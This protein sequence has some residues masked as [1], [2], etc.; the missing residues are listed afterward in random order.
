MSTKKEK[1]SEIVN[2]LNANAMAREAVADTRTRYARGRDEL[3]DLY[4]TP[5]LVIKLWQVEW[6]KGTESK[7][8]GLLSY[9]AE[10][11]IKSWRDI[12]P[13]AVF[14]RFYMD[15]QICRKARKGDAER[16]PERIVQGIGRDGEPV[17]YISVP[18]N[19][20][21]YFRALTEL[22]KDEEIK[23]EIKH[24]VSEQQKKP[25]REKKAKNK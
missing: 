6:R 2:L 16:H 23:R 18:R 9:L 24:S 3:D 21:A 25:K 17:T 5:A 4:A 15:G 12:T 7:C 20:N 11:G 13:K 14:G 8:Q 1:I 22:C 19:L 10:L